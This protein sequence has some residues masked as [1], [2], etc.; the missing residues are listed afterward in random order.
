MIYVR[1]I[2]PGM[3]AAI[4]EFQKTKLIEMH[5]TPEQIK[6]QL[7]ETTKMYDG[8]FGSHISLAAFFTSIGIVIAL[9]CSLILR[10]RKTVGLN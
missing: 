1:L 3:G 5:A 4:G 7:A 10:S 9:I 6:M 2:N 8:S